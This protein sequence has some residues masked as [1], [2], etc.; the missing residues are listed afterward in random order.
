MT[1]LPRTFRD[2]IVDSAEDWASESS[3]IGD[4]FA[5]RLFTTAAADAADADGGCF[6]ERDPWR[7]QPC[8]LSMRLPKTGKLKVDLETGWESYSYP[9]EDVLQN[10]QYGVGTEWIRL[11]RGVPTKNSD[12]SEFELFRAWYRTVQRYTDLAITMQHDILPGIGGLAGRFA[13]LVKGRYA[14]GLW[15]EDLHRGLLWR[16]RGENMPG[17]QRFQPASWSWASVSLTSICYDLITDD[18]REEWLQDWL[19]ILKVEAPLA[20]SNSF[21]EA[22]GGMLHVSSYLRHF[23]KEP[24]SSGGGKSYEYK[25]CELVDSTTSETAGTLC[26]DRSPKSSETAPSVYCLPV[27]HRQFEAHRGHGATGYW[28]GLSEKSICLALQPV[29]AKDGE[30]HLKRVGV[31]RI[32]D[33]RW[34]LKAFPKRGKRVM[35]LE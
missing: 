21:G 25:S 32:T 19:D 12:I 17:K 31:A 26:L 14:T 24:R 18:P 5:N 13:A 2:A 10:V 22:K 6:R 8:Y 20:S 9:Y 23:R 16:V 28:K 29:F 7:L 35:Y 30:E 1:S 3:R 33:Q 34:N 4:Y 11:H 15:V 27:L